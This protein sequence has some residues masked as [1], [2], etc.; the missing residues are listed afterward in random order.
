LNE[1]FEAIQR[2]LLKYRGS[3]PQSL[4]AETAKLAAAYLQN[5]ER[6]SAICPETAEA[7]MRE[8]LVIVPSGTN[9]I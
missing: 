8:N 3:S 6:I 2:G 7:A 9:Y 1:R 5:S 4:T